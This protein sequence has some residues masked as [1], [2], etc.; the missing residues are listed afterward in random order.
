MFAFPQTKLFL[1]FCFQR[2]LRLFFMQMASAAWAGGAG[3]QRGLGGGRGQ[4]PDP[5]GT[6]WRFG[7]YQLDL[8][9]LQWTLVGVLVT[10]PTRLWLSEA[11]TTAFGT[12]ACTALSVDGWASSEMGLQI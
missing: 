12:V 2:N 8:S 4:T 7:L 1:G 9:C 6:G 10:T 3:A 5:L 11:K